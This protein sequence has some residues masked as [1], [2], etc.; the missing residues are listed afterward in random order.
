MGTGGQLSD[1]SPHTPQKR[2]RPAPGSLCTVLPST[3]T[4]PSPAI[5]HS[6]VPPMGLPSKNQ[7]S[8]FSPGSLSATLGRVTGIGALGMP[9]MGVPKYS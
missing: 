9:P 2:V 6:P 3:L 7:I 5:F 1:T 8:T 4:V